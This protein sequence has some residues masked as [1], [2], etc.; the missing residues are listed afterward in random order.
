MKTCIQQI[1]D[2]LF[3]RYSHLECCRDSIMAS[4]EIMC[5]CYKHGHL[6]L[7]CG[8]G[9]SA[10]DAEHITGE[11][12]KGFLLKRGIP[13][14]HKKALEK[15]CPESGAYVSE[16]LQQAL[17][18][19]SLCGA[20]SLST[21]VINDNAS[22]MSFAQLAYGYAHSGDVL[23]AI[24]T[25]GNSK[26]VIYAAITARGQGAKVVSLTGE[27]GGKLKALSDQI[28][29]VPEQET[30]KIQELHLPVYHCLCAML[31]AEFFGLEG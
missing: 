19:I 6:L 23:L 27:G 11:L 29:C 30:F 26:N 21:A 2:E 8:N 7:I 15:I 12:M 4:F 31:E 9:G 16:K 25:S 10:A 1:I 20:P 17:P 14:E 13:A 3:K 22:D 28:I 24:S 18:A 5:D